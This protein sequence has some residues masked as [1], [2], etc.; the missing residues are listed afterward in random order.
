MKRHILMTLWV[1]VLMGLWD[2]Q[3]AVFDSHGTG[4]GSGAFSSGFFH[5]DICNTTGIWGICFLENCEF[6][7]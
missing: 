1:V 3:P 7:V 6:P 5:P 2:W 4:S